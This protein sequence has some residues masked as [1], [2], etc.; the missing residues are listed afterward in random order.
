VTERGRALVQFARARVRQ[1]LG[2]PVA[3]P[4]DAP[5]GR[6]P[7]ATFVT[8]RWR[9]GTLQGCIGNLDADRTIVTDV[10]HNAVAA[11]MR[12]P[13]GQRLVLA[14]LD[15][16]DVELS[17]LSSLEPI[18]STAEIRVG[19]DGVV[20]VHRERR[21][22]FLPV[23]WKVLRD[24]ETFMR[25]LEKKAGLPRDLDRAELRLWRYTAEHHRDP[26]P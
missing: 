13:R 11:A 22:T 1:E 23:M 12:D 18:G 17:I 4:P 26:A 20:L 5:W 7:C 24:L 25:E 2:G 6:E 14:D 10:A 16:L 15:Q 19:T 21:A 9:D 3:V 8:L